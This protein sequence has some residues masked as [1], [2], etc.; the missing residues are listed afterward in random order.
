MVWISLSAFKAVPLRPVGSDLLEKDAL[1][2]K[3]LYGLALTKH[4]A[5]HIGE[6]IEIYKKVIQIKP[7]FDKPY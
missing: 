5:G 1:N 7:D 4:N 3:A 2:Y 6:A